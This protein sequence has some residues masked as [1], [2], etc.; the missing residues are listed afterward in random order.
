MKRIWVILILLC[1]IWTIDSGLW[2]NCAEAN[3]VLKSVVVN[4]SKTKTQK[5]MLKAYLPEEATPEDVVDLGDLKIDYDIDKTLYYVHKEF[6]LGP[7]ESVVRA[8]ELK[9]IWLIDRL[10]LDTLTGKARELAEK[11]KG[12]D[13]FAV[14]L[15]MQRDIEAKSVEILNKQTATMD[16]LPQTHIAAYRDNK[17]MMLAIKDMVAKLENMVIESKFVH[18]SAAEKV[19]VKA[20]WWVILAVIIALGLLSVVFFVIWH[21]QA[22][23]EILKEKNKEET[24]GEKPLYPTDEQGKSTS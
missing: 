8:V 4:P 21:R 19:S 3:V 17:K 2:T 5:A 7:G 13:Y 10:E 14:G 18:P 6:E 9:D 1:L 23:E 12:T 11:L 20:T 16:A 22:S 24:E 15:Q